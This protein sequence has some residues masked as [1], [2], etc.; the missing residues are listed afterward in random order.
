MYVNDR[1]RTITF[2]YSD[3][4]EEQTLQPVAQEALGRGYGVRF[5]DNLFAKADIGFYCQH[6]C[7]PQFS[8][9]SAIFLHDLAQA[10][11]RWPN[12][13]QGE[14]W[15]GFDLGI[16]PGK[17]WSERWQQAAHHHYAHPRHGVF[18][19][20]WPKADHL[21]ARDQDNKT[22]HV[23]QQLRQQLGLK[24]PL[25]VLY[26]PSWENDGKQDSFVRSLCSLPVNLLLK[27]APWSQEYPQVLQAIAEMNAIHATMGKNIHIVHPEVNIFDCMA[28]ADVIVSEESSVLT[29]GLLMRVPGVSVSDW[30]IPDCQPPRFSSVPYDYVWKTP[31]SGLRSL[32]EEMLANLASYQG[33][34]IHHAELHFSCQGQSSRLIID[35]LDSCNG[36]NPLPVSPLSF[37]GKVKPAPFGAGLRHW[38]RGHRLRFKH[39]AKT[40][41]Q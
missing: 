5:S 35:L 26:A 31:L 40:T 39:D 34:I 25:T 11:N 14:P 33:R 13:W 22:A 23:G 1:R 41:K 6:Q 9:F 7:F 36:R 29:E 15:N 19:L 20:G 10:H 24:Y 30:T 37:S 32:V 16:L 21:F 3:K 4:V 18:E 17:T 38:V 27:Q 28:V 8:N 2:F 12:I